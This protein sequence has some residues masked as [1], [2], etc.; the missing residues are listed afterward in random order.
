MNNN[1][2]GIGTVQALN[3]TTV[4]YKN[5]YGTSD[6]GLQCLFV[7][8]QASSLNPNDVTCIEYDASSCG[9]SFY[10]TSPP[11]AAPVSASAPSPATSTTPATTSGTSTAYHLQSIAAAITFVA[12]SLLINE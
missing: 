10:Q 9:L 5:V 4:D 8:R 12:V 2:V 3:G 7:A 1:F 6:S 11:S